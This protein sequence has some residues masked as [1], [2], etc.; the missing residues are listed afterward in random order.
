MPRHHTKREKAA[1]RQARIQS[2]ASRL[3]PESLA[4]M[5]VDLEDA[6]SLAPE[7]EIDEEWPGALEGLRVR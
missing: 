6:E 4:G 7:F 5:L 2:Y 3:S 1:Y